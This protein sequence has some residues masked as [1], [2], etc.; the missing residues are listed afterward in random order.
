MAA[1]LSVC[2]LQYLAP[3][4]YNTTQAASIFGP[5]PEQQFLSQPQQQL[6]PKVENQHE[7][8]QSEWCPYLGH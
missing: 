6:I 8:A 1:Q 5:T 3:P 7:A 4:L 2:T